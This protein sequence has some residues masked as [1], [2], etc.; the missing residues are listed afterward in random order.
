VPDTKV[1]V[2][3]TGPDGQPIEVQPAE[4]TGPGAF[5][6]LFT[7]LAPG[8]HQV[9]PS[10]NGTPLPGTPIVVDVKPEAVDP[11]KCTAEGP[12]VT[13]P[14][15]AGTPAPLTVVPRNR[16]GRPLLNPQAAKDLPIQ[17][18]QKAPSGAAVPVE[19]KDK[20][21]AYDPVPGPQDIEVA[22]DGKPIQ[23]SPFHVE[24][25]ENPNS[26]SPANTR[27]FGPGVEGPIESTM[28]AI[29]TIQ[30]VNPEGA[31]VAQG[32]ETFDVQVCQPS[33]EPIPEGAKV[34][35]NGDGT[36]EGSYS[37][38]PNTFG[39]Y[40]VQVGLKQG[41]LGPVPIKGSAFTVPVA[42]GIDGR[43]ST[44]EGPGVEPKGPVNDTEPAVFL[45]R[46]FDVTGAPMTKG[47]HTVNVQVTA[48]EPAAPIKSEVKDNGD[49]TYEGKYF[50]EAPISHTI[51]VD[52]EGL[53][54]VG[55][56]YTVQVEEG[57]D[58]EQTFT[59][60]SFS[61]YAKSRRGGFLRFGGAKMA[62]KIVNDS[63]GV[64]ILEP[65]PEISDK[66]DGNYTIGFE[67]A[68]PGTYSIIVTMNGRQVKGSPFKQIVS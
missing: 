16:A 44:C 68:E 8:E 52:A 30:A 6:A 1:D 66:G 19:V 41:V 42:P 32:G 33:G 25:K 15:E 63:T 22:V 49:G 28:P 13:G 51:A 5:R 4:K 18:V 3:V 39:D 45:I 17:V 10:I 11:S 65:A 55:S 21:A 35:D 38:V 58:A 27:A 57:P 24:G 9:K 48:G 2:Q 53:P 64:E 36:Y 31:N 40:K 14:V 47:G 46:T 56:P 29:F 20:T 7:P 34:K 23:G 62:V 12:G 67:L 43:K 54:A 26:A 50:P 60:F 37:P 61:V 59:K